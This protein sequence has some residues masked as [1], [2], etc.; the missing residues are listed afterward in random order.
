ML[1]SLSLLGRKRCSIDPWGLHHL[2][3]FVT[4]GHIAPMIGSRYPLLY[5]DDRSHVYYSESE[6]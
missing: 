4:E 3:Y 2:H 1:L 6:I 5:Q